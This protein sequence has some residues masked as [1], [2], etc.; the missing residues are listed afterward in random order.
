[1]VFLLGRT[2][3]RTSPP[4]SRRSCDGRGRSA[5]NCGDFLFRCHR[6]SF[7]VLNCGN[8][9]GVFTHGI[10][11]VTVRCTFKIWDNCEWILSRAGLRSM[12][13]WGARNYTSV[14]VDTK[15]FRRWFVTRK[16]SRFG[17]KKKIH[18]WKGFTILWRHVATSWSW[19]KVSKRSFFQR[20]FY[21]YCSWT[22]TVLHIFYISH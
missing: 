1:M 22:N 18:V 20:L 6:H 11:V 9:H 16:Y 12:G 21:K 3:C 7:I 10:T 15:R 14:N 2:F 4:I 13:L 17:R 19:L 8:L 5:I